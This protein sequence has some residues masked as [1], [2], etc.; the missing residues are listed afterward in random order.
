VADAVDP[1]HAT[2]ARLAALS[3]HD[4]QRGLTVMR[5]NDARYLALLSRFAEH[6]GCDA[7]HS[8]QRGPE[9]FGAHALSP[10]HA[11]AEL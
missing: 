9:A 1:L 6:H 5:G 4:M 10:H 3:G 8:G 11:A 2:L 7:E